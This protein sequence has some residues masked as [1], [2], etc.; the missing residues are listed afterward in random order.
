MTTAIYEETLLDTLR[1]NA[2][3][4]GELAMRYDIETQPDH[5]KEDRPTISAPRDVHE[6]LAPE[7]AHLAQEHL[8]VLL[9]N[10]KNQVVGMRGDL[11]WQLQ[12]L[13]RSARRGA[14]PRRGRV[15]AQ[16]HHQP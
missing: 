16:H 2:L 7:M 5:P 12:L 6:I 14:P 9:L 1:R 11:R 3:V 15:H 8:R 10:A 13:I 4:L